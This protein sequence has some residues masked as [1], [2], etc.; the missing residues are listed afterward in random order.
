MAAPGHGLSQAAVAGA[1][2]YERLLVPGL[3]TP[4][5]RRAIDLAAPVPGERLL[6][7]ACGTGIGARMARPLLGE[8]HALVGVDHD[9]AMLHIAQRA[10]EGVN[11]V[12]AS[13]L[14]LPLR[15]E[16]FDVV[17]CLQGLQFVGD[18]LQAV[19]EAHRVLEPGGRLVA[20]TWG[21]LDANPGHA[22]VY[23]VLEEHHID[24]ALSRRG[25]ALSLDEL[26]G[27]A[28]A[29]GFHSVEG[30]TADDEAVF[31][32]ATAFVE[33]LTQGAPYTRRALAALPHDVRMSC[34][35]QAL[36][37]LTSLSRAGPLALPTR[38]N[39]IIAHR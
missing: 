21:P 6:D 25:F 10:T 12:L 22:A 26:R 32:S 36:R 37:R 18:G 1:A 23:A 34:A 5:T 3:F 2:A 7:L 9:A 27:L 13:V 28:L 30:T 11:W 29:A 24:T 20:T 38:C 31:A 19:R 17:L 15:D 39:L 33:G 8:G 35:Q 16:A 14:Q 4:S